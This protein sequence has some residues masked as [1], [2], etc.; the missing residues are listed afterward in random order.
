MK[1]VNETK[2][3][4]RQ[5]DALVRRVARD[6]D[7]ADASVCVKVKHHTGAH[8]YHGRIY[9]HGPG[10][11]WSDARQEWLW[12]DL[13]GQRHLI[14]CRIAKHYP[15]DNHVY[16]LADVPE[17]WTCG[18]WQEAL[19]SIAGHE[20]MHLRQHVTQHLRKKG[21]RYGRRNESETEWAAFRAWSR[22]KERL[23]KL[24]GGLSRTGERR[25]AAAHGNA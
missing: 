4:T 3:P 17:P 24:C 7:L 9:Y 6:L 12:P 1:V 19:A 25:E 5:V 20:L 2:L 23:E 13:H 15:A 16:D 22:E 11:L 8:A 14:V 18:T 10:A 21:G